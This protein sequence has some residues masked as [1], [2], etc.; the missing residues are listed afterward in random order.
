MHH[1]SPALR[2]LSG[3]KVIEFA[4]LGPAPLCGMLL[5][6][7]GATVLRIDRFGAPSAG[8][9]M[10]NESMDILQRG[11]SPM[12]IDLKHP[13]GRDLALRLI[14]ESDALIEG[15]RPGVM[16]RL[17]LGP[18]VCLKQ[19]PRLVYG[20]VTGWG[21]E[22][23]LAHTAGHDINYL[24]ITGALHMMGTKDSG[25][26]PPINLVGDYAGGTMFLAFGVLAALLQ[27]RTSG[28][29]QIVDA[30][31]IDGVNALL[32]LTMTMQ[33]M[34]QWEDKRQSNLLDGAAPRYSTY[35]C[36]DGQYVAVG[37]LEP[38]FYQRLLEGL[39]LAG[40]ERMQKPDDRSRWATQRAVL[41]EIFKKQT[42]DHWAQL[43]F[44]TDAC[45]SPVLSLAEAPGH[46]HNAARGNVMVIGGLKQP[47]VA[48][49]FSSMP[50]PVPASMPAHNANAESSLKS[51]GWTSD[52]IDLHMKS[53]VIR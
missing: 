14:G 6:D 23:P 11:R 12:A 15:F 44:G 1:E 48:P 43:F 42:R 21:Q 35:V 32:A 31:M 30:A 18:E 25:P 26:I 41:S 33:A 7:L 17:G 10:L 53:G 13:A 5:A 19:H 28:R 29:G 38:Q 37:A 47:A 39:G 9:A 4:G 20:R 16:E 36:S 45:L 34:S 24:A 2:P 46:V 8:Q 51:W 50:V 40:D 3:V 22:G 52:D 27:S 49:R